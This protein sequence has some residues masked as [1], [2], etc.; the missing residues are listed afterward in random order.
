M[1]QKN[2]N[3]PSK[4]HSSMMIPIDIIDIVFNETHS[5]TLQAFSCTCIRYKRMF[6]TMAETC[7]DE[8]QLIASKKEIDSD[9]TVTFWRLLECCDKHWRI[10]SLR[11]IELISAREEMY[12]SFIKFVN[13]SRSFGFDAFADYYYMFEKLYSPKEVEKLFKLVYSLN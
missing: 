10:L 2:D 4:Y 6:E 5:Y 11:K 8:L 13:K 9:K 1:V 12:C 3:V 7:M